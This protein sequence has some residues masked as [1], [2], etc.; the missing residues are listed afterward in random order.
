MAALNGHSK[1]LSAI[2]DTVPMAPGGIDEVAQAA[3]Q[4][5]QALLDV[6][7]AIGPPEAAEQLLGMVR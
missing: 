2:L 4:C 1:L 5:E 3:A 6:T 7:G